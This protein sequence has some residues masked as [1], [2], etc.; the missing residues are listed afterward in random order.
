VEDAARNQVA[1]VAKDFEEAQL[2]VV[3]RSPAIQDLERRLRFAMVA[4]VGGG[5][6]RVS[7]AQVQEALVQ[8]V[9]LPKDGVSVHPY[10]PEDFLVVFASGG[11][12]GQNLGSL[13][14]R[15][16]GHDAH[17]Q[18]VDTTGPGEPQNLAC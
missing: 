7:C 14:R 4:C 17:L 11:A 9:G 15:P 8:I 1:L 18:E 2:C 16:R 10:M 12:A 6:S 5:R 3:R 13:F